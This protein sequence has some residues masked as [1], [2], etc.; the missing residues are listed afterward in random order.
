MA[1][2]GLDAHAEI[3]VADGLVVG[4]SDDVVAAM[5][6]SGEGRTVRLE[7]VVPADPPQQAA[8]TIESRPGLVEPELVT[9]LRAYFPDEPVRAPEPRV[10]PGELPELPEE[11]VLGAGYPGVT[12][13]SDTETKITRAAVDALFADP[14]K[15]ATAARIVP[16]RDGDGFKLYGVRPA[17]ADRFSLGALGLKNGDLVTAVNGQQLSDMSSAMEVYTDVRKAKKLEIDIV[18]RGAPLT[19][20]I[21]VVE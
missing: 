5:R 18:R 1:L 14:S 6:A 12:S 15:R 3:T 2:L 13:V 4:S 9:A 20:T 7:Y 21:E 17:R 8:V 10:P 19:L 16:S 11:G